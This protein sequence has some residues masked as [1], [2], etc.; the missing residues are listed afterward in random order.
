MNGIQEHDVKETLKSMN[1]DK[2]VMYANIKVKLGESF[3]EIGNG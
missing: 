3:G 2:K 1:N